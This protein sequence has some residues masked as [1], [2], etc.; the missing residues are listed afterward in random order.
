MHNRQRQFIRTAE[1]RRSGVN[2]RKRFEL[3]AACSWRPDIR[4]VQASM[5][6]PVCKL[7]VTWSEFRKVAYTFRQHMESL[8]INCKC[9]NYIIQINDTLS[10]GG[11]ITENS[12]MFAV[13]QQYYVGIPATVQVQH[14]NLTEYFKT[15]G[16]TH[17]NS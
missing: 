2:I 4:V 11:Y 16:K 1:I 12:K 10:D 17:Q 6:V 15:D 13:L 5:V 7:N 9:F 3:E 14:H 8:T